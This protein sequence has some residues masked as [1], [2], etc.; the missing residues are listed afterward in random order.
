MPVRTFFKLRISDG[1]M[2]IV[3][4]RV[5]QARVEVD[6]N[7]TGAIG[8]GLLVLLGIGKTDCE[9]DAEY[10][11]EKVLGLRI[12][13]DDTGKMNRSVRDVGGSLLVVSQFTLYGDCRKGRRPSFDLAASPTEAARLYRH[14]VDLARG[15]GTIVETGVFQAHMQVHLINDGP[16]TLICDS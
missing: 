7:I 15:T 3:I 4:Q 9:K 13:P 10:L 16:V 2:R 14:F 8:P 1:A 6:S 11:V 5:K 12:F